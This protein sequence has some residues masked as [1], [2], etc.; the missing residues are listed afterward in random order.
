M[1]RR[2]RVQEGTYKAIHLN[3]N[4]FAELKLLRAIATRDERT[5]SNFFVAIRLAAATIWLIW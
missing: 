5:A 1:N 4:F 3:E 2:A